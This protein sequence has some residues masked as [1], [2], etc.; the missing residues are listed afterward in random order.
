[1]P[2]YLYVAIYLIV[3]IVGHFFVASCLY[4]MRRLVR[5][6]PLPPFTEWLNFFIGGTERSVAWALY[7]WAPSNLPTFIGGWVLLKFAVGWQRRAKEPNVDGDFVEKS[8]ML[9]LIGNI[10]SFATA[11][12]GGYLITAIR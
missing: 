6:K 3:L 1:M 11:I 2:V 9:A 4:A 12:A 10:L 5:V 7:L 8:A